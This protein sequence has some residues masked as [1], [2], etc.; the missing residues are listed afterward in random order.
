MVLCMY[1]VTL[2]GLLHMVTEAVHS[3]NFEHGLHF[4]TFI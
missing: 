4:A 2:N 3:K 1:C